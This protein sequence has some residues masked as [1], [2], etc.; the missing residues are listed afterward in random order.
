M[1]SVSNKDKL[2]VTRLTLRTGLKSSGGSS[3]PLSYDF[4]EKW[5]LIRP[6]DAFED[7]SDLSLLSQ[8]HRFYTLDTKA[9]AIEGKAEI[10]T[11]NFSLTVPDSVADHL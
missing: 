10:S 1:L 3:T 7:L 8:S 4:S 9:T 6:R 5:N 11:S 2:D